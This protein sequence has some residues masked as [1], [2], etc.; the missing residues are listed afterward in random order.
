MVILKIP[1]MFMC[2]IEISLPLRL[3]LTEEEHIRVQYLRRYWHYS[4]FTYIILDTEKSLKL[5]FTKEEKQE[6]S[7]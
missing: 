3:V 4:N 5:F 1:Q 2:N 6:K 7:I